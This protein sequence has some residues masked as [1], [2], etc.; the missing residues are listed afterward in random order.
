MTDSPC[1]AV[2]RVHSP[3][4]MAESTSAEGSRLAI[5]VSIAANVGIA[6]TK[7]TAA[8]VTGSSAMLAEGVHS[9]VDCADGTLLLLGRVRSRRPPDARHPFGYGRELYFWTL[10]VAILFFALGGG[11]SAYEGITHIRHPEPIRDPTWNYVV[12]GIAALFDGSSFVVAIREFRKTQRG[13][14]FW[15]TVRASKDPTVF[16]VVL[17]DSADLVGLTLAALGVYFGHRLDNPYLDGIASVGIGLVMAAVAVI[18]I[19]ESKALLIGEGA[20]P[21]VVACIE[22]AARADRGLRSIRPPHTIH[23]SPTEVA[24]ALAVEVHPELSAEEVAQAVGRLD[25]HIRAA[26]PAVKHVYIDARSVTV[27]PAAAPR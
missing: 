27:R 17:E 7:L 8:V 12:L 10:V 3:L 20:D 22:A 4:R 9:L 19:V 11:V 5:Y 15:E 13:R 16:T 24:V 2:R 1:P 26:V 14:G 23:M 18:L 6:A 25:A 21:E